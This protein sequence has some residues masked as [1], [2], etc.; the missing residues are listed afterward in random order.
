M[1]DVKAKSRRRQLHVWLTATDYTL[2]AQDAHARDE[3]ISALIRR[4]LRHYCRSSQ[5]NDNSS[6]T[7]E[8][9]GVH[10]RG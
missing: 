3:P 1:A 5:V 10:T 8:T 9:G 7:V 4:I 2:L 6:K